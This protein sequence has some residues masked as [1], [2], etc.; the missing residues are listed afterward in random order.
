MN[1]SRVWKAGVLSLIVLGWAAAGCGTAS[2]P[3]APTAQVG[4][5]MQPTAPQDEIAPPGQPPVPELPPSDGPTHDG[6]L[7]RLSG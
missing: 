3:V 1:A 7:V 4:D 5:G 6:D 2:S